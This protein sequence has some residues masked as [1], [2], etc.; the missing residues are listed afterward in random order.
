MAAAVGTTASAALTT[1]AAM[2]PT[3][4]RRRGL[5]TSAVLVSAVSSV[6]ATKPACTAMVSQARADVPSANSASDSGTRGCG[7]KPDGHPEQ[8]TQ[9]DQQQHAT[10]HDRDSTV[11]ST[12]RAAA[13]AV[14]DERNCR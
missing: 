8:L 14:Y 10:G 3:R 11:G 7:G 12:P 13:F 5:M 9:R 4:N 6:P 1:A 2:P